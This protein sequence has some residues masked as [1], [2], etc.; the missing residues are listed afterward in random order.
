MFTEKEIQEILAQGENSSVEFKT[1]AIRPEFLA[2]K[3]VAFANTNGAE[4]LRLFQAAGIFH[5][6]NVAVPKTSI[7]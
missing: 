3:M 6:D 4:L 1:V 2:R 7:N 5:Y